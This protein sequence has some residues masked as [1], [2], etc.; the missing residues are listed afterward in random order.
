MRSEAVLV[1]NGM[2]SIHQYKAKFKDSPKQILQRIFRGMSKLARTFGRVGVL[3]EGHCGQKIITDLEKSPDGLVAL[4]K[5][6]FRLPTIS[7]DPQRV[8][9]LCSKFTKAIRVRKD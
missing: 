6:R 1:G 5:I 3:D 2:Y 4:M 8:L 9:R 7:S